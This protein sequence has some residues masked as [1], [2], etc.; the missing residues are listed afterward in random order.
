MDLIQSAQSRQR[1]PAELGMV[2][3]DHDL[4]AARHHL[5]LGLDQER[6]RVVNALGDDAAGTQDGL[7]HPDRLHRRDRQRPQCDARPRVNVAADQDQVG[8]LARGEKLR[9]RQAV[10]DDLNAPADQGP[11]DLERR[12]AAIQEDRVAIFDQ[13]SRRQADRTLL[14]AAVPVRSSKAGIDRTSPV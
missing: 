4:L 12:R 9:D 10:G 1:Q 11:S 3:D 8:L 7:A 14:G 13:S 6:V 2:R 5:A